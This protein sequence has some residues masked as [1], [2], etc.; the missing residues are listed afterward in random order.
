MNNQG[1]VLDKCILLLINASECTHNTIYFQ[2]KM[3]INVSI[4][5]SKKILHIHD[6]KIQDMQINSISI[7]TCL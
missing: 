5:H 1:T 6:C 3:T 4:L 2:N 7:Y